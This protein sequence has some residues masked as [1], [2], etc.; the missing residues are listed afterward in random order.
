MKR[1][2]AKG[3]KCPGCQGLLVY[4]ETVKLV[5]P[6]IQHREFFCEG[7]CAGQVAEYE[8]CEERLI[9]PI[10]NELA[11]EAINISWRARQP[12]RP[13]APKRD[14]ILDLLASMDADEDNR[15]PFIG[16]PGDDG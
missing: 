9:V 16:P 13:N 14:Q 2:P 12:K 3:M 8:F 7:K 15:C 1:Y 10:T 6:A 4:H 5:A 11:Q